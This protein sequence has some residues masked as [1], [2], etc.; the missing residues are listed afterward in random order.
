MYVTICVHVSSVLLSVCERLCPC[1]RNA[2]YVCVCLYILLLCYATTV[3]VTTSI[4]KRICYRAA[5]LTSSA[6][7]VFILHVGVRD[8]EDEEVEKEE[9]DGGRRP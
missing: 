2:C 9:H 4:L 7:C 5:H 6:A 3:T 1:I 8:E